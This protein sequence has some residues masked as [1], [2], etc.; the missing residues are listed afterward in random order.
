M[1][2]MQSLWVE[3]GFP[4]AAQL[5]C[6]CWLLHHYPGL[7]NHSL[8]SSKRVCT[9]HRELILPWPPQDNLYGWRG[10]SNEGPGSEL[11]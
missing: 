2:L 8:G 9:D 10:H 3:L 4:R 6:P 1:S 7:E 11:V 5:P